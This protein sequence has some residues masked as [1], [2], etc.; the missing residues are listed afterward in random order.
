MLRVITS[1]KTTNYHPLDLL[2]KLFR[3]AERDKVKKNDLVS[4]VGYAGHVTMLP[5]YLRN[6][7]RR[8]LGRRN[9][10]T[11]WTQFV[12]SSLFS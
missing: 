10:T 2:E 7:A 6:F 11:T 4:L 8:T 3:S 12:R 1:G 9:L 5:A